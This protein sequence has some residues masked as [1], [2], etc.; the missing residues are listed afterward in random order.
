MTIKFFKSSSDFRKWLEA[1]HASAPELWVGFYK[2]TSGRSSI[3]WP[4][5]VDQALCF[6]WID[7]IRKSIDDISY[8]IRFTPR[9]STS[10]WSTVNVRRALALTNQGLMHPKGLEALEKR[11]DNRSGIYSYEQRTD[12]MPEPY[13]Q[14]LRANKAAWDFFQTQV[15]SYRKVVSWW[16]VSAKKEETRQKRLDKLIEDSA[17]RRTIDQYTRLQKSK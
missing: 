13:A 11:K 6:G 8:K 7:G 15:P 9:K 10:V 14:K 2:K 5:S 4:E 17:Q 1:N 3:T 16:V 12:A